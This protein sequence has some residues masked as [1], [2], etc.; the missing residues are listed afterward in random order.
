MI[1]S[2]IYGMKQQVTVATETTLSQPITVSDLKKFSEELNHVYYFL[3][4]TTI[5]YNSPAMPIFVRIRCNS[6]TVF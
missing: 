1:P 4:V 6:R 2:N 5:C 3:E